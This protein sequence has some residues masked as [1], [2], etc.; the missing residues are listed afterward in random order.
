MSE[1]VAVVTG[2]SRGIGKAIALELARAGFD[3]VVVARTVERK[4]VIPGTIHETVAEVEA[5]GRRAAAVQA[6]LS[7]REDIG[8]LVEEAM[9]AFGR[10]DVLVNNAAHTGTEIMAPF[11]ETTEGAWD[12]QLAINMTA[13]FL[14]M[15]AFGARMRDQGGGLVVNLTSGAARMEY[16]G[17]VPGSGDGATGAGYPTT[18][19]ALDRLAVVL[20][21]ELRPFGIAVV[22]V[23][24]GAT[25][26]EIME[27]SAARNPSVV[28]SAH[29]MS[30]PARAVMRLATS[31]D[32][33][34]LSGRVVS[35]VEVLEELGA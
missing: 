16:V 10:V 30:V 13:P 25:L 6:D 17:P 24:P 23:D 2:A 11:F 26:T 21:P 4:R 9:A 34:R 27:L 19:A 15:Q 29:P 1:R 14:L 20:A 32:V 5:L 18:K 31:A 28:A 7:R 3:V 8:R 35:A 22:N 33:M 12:R